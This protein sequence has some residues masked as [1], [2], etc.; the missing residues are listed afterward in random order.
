MN[1]TESLLALSVKIYGYFITVC[2]NE[3]K[4]FDVLSLPTIKMGTC[5][6]DQFLKN[7]A[8]V[9]VCLLFVCL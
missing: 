5:N 9:L 3:K 4:C 1:L 7:S 2:I 6:H 8:E